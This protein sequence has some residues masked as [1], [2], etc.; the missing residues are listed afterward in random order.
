MD[1]EQLDAS[2]LAAIGRLPWADKFA[3]SIALYPDA[4]RANFRL[5]A[6]RLQAL[7][8]KGKI[9]FYCGEWRLV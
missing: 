3:V 6:R 7:R 9:R 8:Q 2:I 5:V 4:S 1:N